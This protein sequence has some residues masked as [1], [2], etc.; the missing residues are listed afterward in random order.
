MTTLDH[1]LFDD[2]CALMK[3]RASAIVNQ[4]EAGAVAHFA[5]IEK[6]LQA[7]DAHPIALAAH[8]L[9]SSSANL[10]ALALS[11]IA[12]QLE[13]TAKQPN[14]EWDEIHNLSQQMQGLSQQAIQAMRERLPT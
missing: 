9:K 4:F 5:A 10:G 3:N 13:K 2:V 7:Q 8:T 11:N 1:A 14:P 12:A 6:G